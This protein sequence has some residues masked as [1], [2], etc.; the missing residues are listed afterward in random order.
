MSDL[1]LS[2]DTADADQAWCGFIAETLPAFLRVY[3]PGPELAVKWHLGLGGPVEDAQTSKAYF[4]HYQSLAA[5]F[6][7]LT[8]WVVDSES[9]LAARGLPPFPERLVDTVIAVLYGLRD[10]VWTDN[11]VVRVVG[12][13]VLF[14]RDEFSEDA[15]A[16]REAQ[17]PGRDGESELLM[18]FIERFRLASEI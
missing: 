5:M 8:E 2:I 14:L 9:L 18:D 13:L 3:F 11:D 4:H 15:A 10:Q 17:L 7:G 16:A 6:E 12:S 1:P